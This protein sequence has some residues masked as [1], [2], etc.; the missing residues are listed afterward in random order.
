[1][2]NVLI[3]SKA[4]PPTQTV[5]GF[6]A[7]NFVK[8]LPKYGWKPYVITS[9]SAVS[10]DRDVNSFENAVSEAMVVNRCGEVF[11]QFEFEDG[12]IRWTPKLIYSV[13][14][15][16]SKY[17]IDL[18]FHTG[19]PFLPMIAELFIK[20]EIDIPYVIDLRD[21]WTLRMDYTDSNGLF[22]IL[23]RTVSRK[24]EPQIFNTANKII[25]NTVT[26]ENEY[27]KKYPHLSTKFEVI[28]NGFEEH[29]I[30]TKKETN[31]RY[32]IVYPGKFYGDI[33]PLVRSLS[34]F[35]SLYPNSRLVHFGK[36]DRE[37]SQLV[38]AYDIE[39]HVD[40][41]GYVDH[42]E[43]I[44]TIQQSDLGLA[45]GRDITQVP[46]K[47]YD[48]LSCN[49]PVVALCPAESELERFISNFPGG[50]VARTDLGSFT[51]IFQ[52]AREEYRSQLV[53]HSERSRYTWESLTQSL[54][55]IFD[56][57]IEN[58]NSEN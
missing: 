10:S 5:G 29:S 54:I 57:M 23:Y 18:V 40:L 21:P 6:R 49:I 26:M 25:L 27:L 32:Q 11:D 45:I 14:Q 15:M 38:Q 22:S 52:T 36:P 12:G 30:R 2:P 4:F 47:V 42:S 24:L 34:Q 3:I 35:F 41:R 55:T 51:P 43:V 28:T 39:E 46:M 44:Y 17:D 9:N 56:S 53:A 33:E 8:W 20:F 7:A 16:I 13:R 37:F 31:D 58:D 48:Y 1:M 19:G 50:Y